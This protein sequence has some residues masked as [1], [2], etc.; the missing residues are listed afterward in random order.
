[1]ASI[2]AW[3]K[4]GEEFMNNVT[5]RDVIS[6][7]PDANI[8]AWKGED[9]NVKIKSGGKTVLLIS[10]KSFGSTM[11]Q[12]KENLKKSFT[13]RAVSEDY[14]EGEMATEALGVLCLGNLEEE[15]LANLI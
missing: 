10:K 9:P 11:E 1:M 3:S 5:L 4:S 2:V 14:R 8:S 7:F 6:E 15:S 12:V 13:V